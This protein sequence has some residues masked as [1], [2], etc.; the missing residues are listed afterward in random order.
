VAIPVTAVQI[1][2]GAEIKP[3]NGIAAVL[4]IYEIIGLQYG[5]T[6]KDKHGR[7]DH[8]IGGIDQNEVRVRGIGGYYRISVGSVF[9]VTMI[10]LSD[11]IP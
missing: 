1:I 10:F 9:V 2:T 3:L 4:P 5:Y 8:V 11:N 7:S 6:W